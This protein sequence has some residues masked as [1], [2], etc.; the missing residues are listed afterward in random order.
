[1]Y[2][3][4][5]Q[6]L[7]RAARTGAHGLPLMGTGDWNDGMNRVG[8]E[9][10]G[11]SVWV[12]FFLYRT[13]EDFALLC[14][15]RGDHE[16]LARHRRYQTSLRV[17][18]EDA[19][20]DGEWYR[21]AYYDDG[22][23]LGSASNEE[24]RI[25]AIAQAWSVISGAAPRERAE[26]AIDAA[27]THLVSE[28][29]G[30]IR[31]LAPPFDRDPH[32][33]GYIKGYVPGIREN[34]GQY[35][36]GALWVVQ[37]LAELGRRNQAAP[38][39]AMLTPVRHALTTSDVATYQVEPYVVA[40]DVYGTPPHVGR[41]G[42]T[43]YTGSAGWVYRV[44]MES[45]LGVR[46][47]GGDTLCVRPCV[48]DAWD[49]FTVRLRLGGGTAY[50]VVVSNPTHESATVTAVVVDG[51]P[52]AVVEGGARV[53]LRHDGHVHRVAVTLGAAAR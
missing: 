47:E 20:W 36:H 32:D 14:E 23:P 53:A 35:T 28:R 33:P 18:L 7:H 6:A 10:R 31:L 24:C 12:G 49:G 21:S 42:W 27:M 9:G 19:G 17:A 51:A 15:R 1:L 29:E 52:V 46:I 2:L 3:H 45:I 40:A 11:E 34:G 48:P 26:R 5:L 16:R 30:L 41:G 25:D 22:T 39:L 4:C 8:R 43:W 37:A 44:A 50:E 38:T 13:L